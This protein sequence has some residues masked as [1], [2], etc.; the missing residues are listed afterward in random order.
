[1]QQSID[2]LQQMKAQT[3]IVIAHRLSTVRNADKIIVINHGE[4]VETGTHDEL[5]ANTNGLYYELWQKQNK[6]TT[7]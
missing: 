4:I 3:T 2:S 1:M 5:V 7:N 6:A